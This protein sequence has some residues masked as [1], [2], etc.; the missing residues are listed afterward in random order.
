[1]NCQEVMELMQRYID[2]DLD[3]PETSL[4]M[5]HVG[6]CP[7]CA[8]MLVRLQ[9]LSSELAQ[10]PRVVPRYSLVDAILPELERLYTEQS[11]GIRSNGV[12]SNTVPSLLRSKR[13]SRNL[14][15][16]LSGVVAAGVVVGLLLFSQPL[17]WSF[18]GSVSNDAAAPAPMAA[19][20]E[21]ASSFSL[22][23]TD[24]VTVTSQVTKK[25]IMAD[26]SKNK[27]KEPDQGTTM[28]SPSSEPTTNGAMMDQFGI[29]DDKSANKEMLEGSS[30]AANPSAPNVENG[31]SEMAIQ[32]KLSIQASAS[33]SPDGKW[34]AI[35]V[36][37]AGT[38]Q[39]YNTA[40]ESELFAS[41]AREGTISYLSWNEDSTLLYYTFTDSTGLQTAL[42]F[43]VINV[44]ETTR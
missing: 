33:V 1:M 32:P 36:D 26:E 4:M 3:Q 13:P 28:A 17:N 19:Q 22:E 35:A 38:L 5:D 7:D 10:L 34:R 30:S 15:R 8:A 31:P 21:D 11:D 6:Q 18:S 12:D 37:G 29:A 16:K 24:T 25:S 39:V 42:M 23:A 44:K 41:E 43:D 40:D 20:N 2:N 14:I 27:A 9:T